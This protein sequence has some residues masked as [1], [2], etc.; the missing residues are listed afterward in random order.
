MG[1]DNQGGTEKGLTAKA[2][3]VDGSPDH[4]A[5]IDRR[6]FLGFAA[7]GLPMVGL[8]SLSP[9][10]LSPRSLSALTLPAPGAESS[11]PG[12]EGGTVHR[13]HD[14]LT[15][16]QND[17]ERVSAIVG[18]SHGNIDRVRELLSEQPALARASWDWGFGDWET[19]LGA[20]AHT[21]RREI[22]ELLIENGARPNL[23]SATM[24][25]E[26]ATV[27]AFL[28]ADPSLYW[29]PGPHGIPLV[30]HA[31]AGREA[32][33][34]VLEYLLDTF[35]ADERPFGVPETDGLEAR[36]S[37]RFELADD[38]RFG[39]TVGIRNGWLMVGAGEEPNARVIE[40]GPD[41]FHPSAS[42][43]VLLHFGVTNGRAESLTVNDGP[44]H[45]QLRRVE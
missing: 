23:F 1:Q 40:S 15:F 2:A 27:Q 21:G 14:P 18:A 24:M 5:G 11:P 16:P 39:V 20:A 38:A 43:G 19:A 37:G 26:M 28:T 6:H 4:E 31:R 13:R 34:P 9:R 35:G 25:G 42:P 36:Y 44:L 41:R 7:L 30:N 29:L 45:L 32:A 10:A 3:G 8:G 22:A 17:P 33:A 12:P